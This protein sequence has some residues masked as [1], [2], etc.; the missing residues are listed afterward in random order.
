MVHRGQQ[1]DL[2]QAGGFGRA[3]LGD[4]LVRFADQD[5][6]LD[7]LG[8]DEATLGLDQPRAMPLGET[9]GP[10]AYEVGFA[11]AGYRVADTARDIDD[12]AIEDFS[13]ACN[14]MLAAP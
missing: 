5:P 8:G 11:A 7:R 1:G 3:Q 14:L 13:R 6:G 12:Y 2:A 9:A 10:A 4:D